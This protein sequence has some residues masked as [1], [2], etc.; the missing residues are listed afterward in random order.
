MCKI[1]RLCHEI[2]FFWECLGEQQR[3]GSLESDNGMAAK[4]T[5]IAW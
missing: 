4:K 5:T 2:V 1:V 3:D